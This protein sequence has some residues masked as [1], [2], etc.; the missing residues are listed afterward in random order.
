MRKSVQK[1]IAGV[2]RYLVLLAAACQ[3]WPAAF[4]RVVL[5][6]RPGA[7]DPYHYDLRVTTTSSPV[8]RPPAC[9]WLLH[10]RLRQD[11][12]A[13]RPERP[14]GARRALTSRTATKVCEL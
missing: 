10:S 11:D 3:L 8:R 5:Y 7:G 4:G 1:R 6:G 2:A 13:L 12:G 9:R 14:A